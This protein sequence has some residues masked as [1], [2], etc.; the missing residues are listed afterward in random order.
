MTGELLDGQEFDNEWTRDVEGSDE[1]GW[2]S[3]KEDGVEES[4]SQRNKSSDD[5]GIAE[6]DCEMD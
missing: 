2:D 5:E 1:L 6:D 4:E 3:G